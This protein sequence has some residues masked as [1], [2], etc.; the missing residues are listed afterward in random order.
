MTADRNPSVEAARML[1]DAGCLVAR[2]GEPFRLPSGWTTPVY[3]DCRRVTALPQVR[4]VLIERGVELLRARGCLAG[5]ECVVGCEASGIAIAAWVAD[6]LGLP[7]QFVRKRARGS[8]RVEGPSLKG[9]KVL[10]VDD[11]VAAGLT[12]LDFITA[13][14]ESGARVQDLFV[15]FDYGT[16]GAGELLMTRGVR[17]HA[18]ATWADVLAAARSAGVLDADARSEFEHFLDAPRR[19]SLEHGGKGPT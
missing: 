4:R 19:W 14:Q 13:L 8:E 9:R 6:E 11:L 10:L 2:S 16:F 12:K 5:V 3:M 7:M 1:L 15:I 17:T 18:L